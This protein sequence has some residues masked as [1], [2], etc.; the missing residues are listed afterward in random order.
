MSSKRCAPKF[1]I[2]STSL[3][4]T[5]VVANNLSHKRFLRKEMRVRVTAKMQIISFDPVYVDYQSFC[6][7]NT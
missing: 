6:F 2:L 4:S 5:L 1:E 3:T 7:R